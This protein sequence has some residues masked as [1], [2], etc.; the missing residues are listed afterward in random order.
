M[1]DAFFKLAK[2]VNLLIVNQEK[3]LSTVVD[4]MGVVSNAPSSSYTTVAGC[5]K[6]KLPREQSSRCDEFNH[7]HK[8]VKKLRSVTL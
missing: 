1:S 5:G 4:A 3:M 6:Q 8:K 7:P 2:T